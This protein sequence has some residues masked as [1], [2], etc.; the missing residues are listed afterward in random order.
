MPGDESELDAQSV[1]NFQPVPDALQAFEGTKNHLEFDALVEEL[2]VA[3]M[4]RLQ[5]QIHDVHTRITQVCEQILRH[6]IGPTENR[7]RDLE[8][9][10]TQ[11]TTQIV[12]LF[13]TELVL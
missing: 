10:T 12:D 7:E 6:H 1:V 3:R 8:R 5:T 9:Q 11:P 2:E 13:E 4:H